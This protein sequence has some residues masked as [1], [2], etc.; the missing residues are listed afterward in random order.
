LRILV[1]VERAGAYASILL[2]RTAPQIPDPRDAALMHELVLG[3]LRRRAAL[4]H[5]VNSVASRP[6]ERMHPEVLAALRIG[7]YSLLCL[8]RVPDFAAVDS[9]VE[10]IRARRQP[11]VGFVN[12]VLREVARRGRELLPSPPQVGDCEALALAESHPL[13]WTR[14]TVQ[15][16][17]WERTVR[18]MKRNNLPATT[19]LRANT[20][21]IAV[22]ELR[23]LLE[24][25][26]ASTEPGAFVAAAV[27]LQSGTPSRSR[28]IRDGLAWVQDEASQLIPHLMGERPGPRVVDLCA[29][30]GSKTVQIASAAGQGLI[31]ALDR[32]AGRLKRLTRLAGTVGADN[33]VACVADSA[34]ALPVGGRIDQVLVDAPCSGTGT[35]RRH[36]EIRW[37]LEPGDLE[38]LARRQAAL[39]ASGASLVRPGGR[40]VYSVCSMEREEG[41]EVVEGF[42]DRHGDFELRDPGPDLPTPAARL[43]ASDRFLH[44]SPLD[45]G[46]DGFFGAL[47]IRRR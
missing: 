4:D 11:S 7:T 23:R 25:E 46:I 17:G 18:L 39:L 5:V 19:V 21:R 20:R 1:R 9:A 31:V 24:D 30:P 38:H 14:R 27:R 47:L 3:V 35:L 10:L 33:V 28:S 41:E 34:A 37:R 2:D 26:G 29:A 45:A 22:S 32:H 8:D 40:L 44:T 36:P 6:V 42:L 16:L 12:A 43:V 13:W 15:R